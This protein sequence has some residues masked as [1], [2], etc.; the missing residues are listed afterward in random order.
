MHA[1]CVS[2]GDLCCTSQREWV[3]QWV[4]L[5]GWTADYAR[6]RYQG[7]NDCVSIAGIQQAL[8]QCMCTHVVH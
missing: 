2:P 5:Y 8:G 6:F 7:L 3:A 4:E 1:T